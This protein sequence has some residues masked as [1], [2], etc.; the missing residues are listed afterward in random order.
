MV[1]EKGFRRDPRKN[2]GHIT[3]TSE[4]TR[5]AA[6]PPTAH[7]GERDDAVAEGSANKQQ[8]TTADRQAL[9]R[10]T[11]TEQPIGDMRMNAIKFTTRHGKQTETTPSEDTEETDNERV[12]LEPITHDTEGLDPQL[13]SQGTNKEV[14]Q[15]KDQSVFTEIDGNTMTPE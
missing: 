11:T 1:A 4:T 15:M 3:N 14:Q 5:I 7:A 8:R 10:P 6:P 9:E 13:V 12:L 2:N